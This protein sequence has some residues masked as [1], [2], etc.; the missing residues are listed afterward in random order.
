VLPTIDDGD[1]CTLDACDPA[2][3]ITHAACSAVGLTVAT[4]IAQA[5]EFLSTGPNAVQTGV[6]AGALDVRRAAVIR[7]QVRAPDGS[8]LAGSTSQ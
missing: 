8:L 7:G 2:A 6:A 4:A 5:S 1:P 3:G